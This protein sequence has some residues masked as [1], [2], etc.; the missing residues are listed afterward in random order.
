MSDQH[1]WFQAALAAGA[2]LAGARAVLVP[3]RP[4]RGRRAA[5]ERLGVGVRRAGLV[6]RGRAGRHPEQ[7]YL[8][9]FAPGQPDLNWGHP[10]VR[11]RAR[12][13]PAVLV[14]PRRRRHPDRLRRAARQGLRRCPR[15]PD[16][17]DPGEHPY[18]DREELQDIYRGWRRI[19]DSYGPDRVL[20]GEIWLPD[21]ERFARYLRPDV[22]HTAFNFDFM[23][24]PWDADALRASIEQT[25]EVHDRVGA[26]AT[27]VL[28]NHDVTRPV[29]RYG[30]ADTSFAFETQA[31]R[32]PDRPRARAPAGRA[33]PPCSPWRCPAPTTCTRAR[34]SGCPRSRTSPSDRIEDPMH[35]RSGGVDPGR[36]GCRV[37]LPWSGDAPPYGFSADAGRALAAP[38]R[39]L[40]GLT[41]EPRRP[42]TPARCS[43]STGPAL[44]LRHEQPDLGDGAARPGSTSGRTSSPSAA[45][46]AS[47]PSPTS[48]PARSTCRSPAQTWL[49]SVPLEGGRLP[50]DTTAWLQLA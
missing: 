44:R 27:W 6:P 12:G 18:V 46:T 1:A 4:R 19:A 8:H 5:A 48:R 9:L 39:R 45:A 43:R 2:G 40:G 23:A 26:P 50:A 15:S 3:R 37:P 22:L 21:A 32:H 13:D 42:A 49:A 24:S 41:V 25:L 31:V 30:R 20:I 36:D 16:E 7:W 35:A 17:P 14:R 28:S 11:A 29:T 38:A 47:C 33:Q 10:D 34:S